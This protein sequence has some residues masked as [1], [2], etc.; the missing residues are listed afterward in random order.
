MSLAPGTECRPVLAAK[1]SAS[2][3]RQEQR[4]A[5]VCGGWK[6]PEGV[7]GNKAGTGMTEEGAVATKCAPRVDGSSCRVGGRWASGLGRYSAPPPPSCSGPPELPTPNDA[8]S[9]WVSGPRVLSEPTDPRRPRSVTQ[10]GDG[11]LARGLPRQYTLGIGR[12][13][14][15]SR[16]P[17]TGVYGARCAAA[18][19]DGRCVRTCTRW[20]AGL[21]GPAPAAGKTQKSLVTGRAL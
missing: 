2:R 7:Q 3:V 11:R 20:A 17:E 12:G 18:R 9:P 8:T 19:G 21:L 15:R 6:R 13:T 16:E 14:H 10:G 4:G 5:G 1:V